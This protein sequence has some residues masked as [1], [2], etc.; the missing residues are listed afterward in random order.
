M[1][2]YETLMLLRPDVTRDE[3]SALEKDFAR[4]IEN[5]QGTFSSFDRWGK[6]ELAYPV[7]KHAYGIYALA[8][9]EAAPAHMQELLH[10][11]QLHFRIKSGDIVMRHVHYALPEGAPTNYKR[12]EALDVSS[13]SRLDPSVRRFARSIGQEDAAE[14][15]IAAKEREETTAEQ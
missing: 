5:V 12:P 7:R 3:F 13:E 9:F 10:A 2:R 6:Y 14:T 15:P 1:T 4:I 11:L 8:R